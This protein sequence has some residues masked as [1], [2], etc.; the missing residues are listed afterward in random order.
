M[1]RLESVSRSPIFADFSQA[2]SGVSTIRAYRDQQRFID[3]LEH[4]LDQNSIAG[5]TIQVASNWLAIRLDVMGSSTSFFI[6]VVAAASNGFLPPGFV[7]LG[8][9]YSFLMTS[10]L[11]FA[12]RMMATG[13]A[14]MNSVERL[15][16]Y[17]DN[18]E[19]EGQASVPLIDPATLPADWP[20]KGE[21][22]ASNIKMSYR[23][24][25]LV[26]KGLDFAVKAGEKIGIAGRTG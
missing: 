21:V 11:K 25:P 7:A 12:V 23:D 20:V 9:M 24:G 3:H 10:F 26:I 15:K 22:T 8:L 1:A 13:E 19:Q 2:L 18:V 14:Q 4:R 16:H 6:A 17:A 5:M